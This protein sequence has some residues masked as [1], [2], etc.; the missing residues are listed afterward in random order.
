M[1]IGEAAEASGVTAKMIRHYEAIGLIPPAGRR[2]SN[3]RDYGA[4]DVHRL[5][6]IRRARDL[7][8]SIGEIRE[9]LRL[10]ADRRRSSRDVKALALRHIAELEAKIATLGEMRAT[11][12]HLAHCCDGDSRPDCPIIESLAG[13]VPPPHRH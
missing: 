11:L 8:F 5:A 7:G 13:T 9:L 1:Q 2:S 10:W 6:F 3:Y 12:A 4:D